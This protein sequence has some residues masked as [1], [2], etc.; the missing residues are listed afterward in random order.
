MEPTDARPQGVDAD[1]PPR[2]EMVPPSA[3]GLDPNPLTPLASPSIEPGALPPPHAV[4]TAA[5]STLSVPPPA[6]S[7]PTASSTPSADT[8]VLQDR[9]AF[10]P[11]HDPTAPGH[12][13][14]ELATPSRLPMLPFRILAIAGVALGLALFGW[15]VSRVIDEQPRLASLAIG[16]A[17]AGVV[18]AIGLV[19]W[20][21]VV[22]ENAR[23][24][25]DPAT[26]QQ[27]PQPGRA[28][29]T[30][31]VP[32]TFVTISTASVAYLSRRFN[33]PIEGTESSVP[34]IL[35]VLTLLISFAL[36][37]TPANCLSGVVR[38]IGG[39]GVKLAEWLL[40]PV[41]LAG[42]G[43]AM[44]FGLRAGGA[45]A[46][47]ADG[48]VP[49]WAVGVAAIVPA[50]VLVLLGWRAAAAVETDIASAFHRRVGTKRAPSR[51]RSLFP[52]FSDDGPNQALLREKGHIRQIPGGNLASAVI[53]ASMA[54]LALLSVVGAVVMYLFWQEG[55]D[56][57][58]LATQSEKAWDVLA[59]LQSAERNVAL[60]AM[61]VATVW[62]GIA[63]TNVRMASARRRNPLIGSLSWPLAGAGIWIIGDRF[64]ADADA[65]GV[66]LGFAAQAALLYIPFAVLERSAEAVSSRRNPIRYAYALGVVLLVY[67]QGLGGLSNLTESN[68]SGD[69][70]RIAGY[71]AVGALVQLLAMF[72]VTEASRSL[73]DS[74]RHL[75]DNHN[76]LVSQHSAMAASRPGVAS[77]EPGGR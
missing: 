36:M 29:A 9:P 28:A 1:E 60:V 53:T 31:V 52:S 4:A 8:L 69:V 38:K 5:D 42:V 30:W 16:S 32:L 44:I 58:L 46:D 68:D 21:F 77:I 72:A 15:Q 33:T 37:Y 71:L 18:G 22:V 74:A 50:T 59:T 64:V 73:V 34:L 63:V 51:R 48:L 7:G 6:Q 3:D 57:V 23:R 13:A 24:V 43:V 39:R 19:L 67:I 70:G 62:A 40:V 35:G 41:A 54:G 61:V 20:T 65:I 47:D 17:I 76:Q 56:G 25:M 12:A 14:V 45:Y 2:F 55:R 11:V 66:V 49:T 75:A 10:E 26:T 27:L